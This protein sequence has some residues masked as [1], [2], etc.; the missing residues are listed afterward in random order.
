M[1]VRRARV[2][3][4]EALERQSRRRDYMSIKMQTSPPVKTLVL[5][6]QPTEPPAEH[7]LLPGQNT[8]SGSSSRDVISEYGS[9]D[10]KTGT[11]GLFATH[12]S[13][14]GSASR[15]HYEPSGSS[16]T[17][18]QRSQMPSIASDFTAPVLTQIPVPE[19]DAIDEM[20]M[21][22]EKVPV[23]EDLRSEGS[24]EKHSKEAVKTDNE[25]G[26]VE[27]TTTKT[28]VVDEQLLP[29]ESSSEEEVECTDPNCDGSDHVAKP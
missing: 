26:A 16:Y 24:W 10:T 23:K 20:K 3:Q 2:V 25:G 22:D 1:D 14:S 17:V 29:M 13:S 21:I 7:D 8:Q 12:G 5:K 18:S 27:E 15:S 11:Q 28:G 19:E 9:E 6:P 4:R